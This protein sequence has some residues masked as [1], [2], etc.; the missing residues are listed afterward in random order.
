MDA[1]VNLLL[2][3]AFFAFIGYILVSF[4][5]QSSS[6]GTPADTHG[7]IKVITTPSQFNEEL[8]LAGNKPVVVDFTA[9]WCGPCQRIAPYFAELSNTYGD[10]MIFMKVDVDKLSGIAQSY[11]VT[12]MPTFQMI[13]NGSAVEKFAGADTGRLKS[14]VLKYTKSS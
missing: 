12:A 1:I 13:V 10:S 9:T 2:S 4:R 3:V 6:T 11:G 7:K 14:F 5:N 8:G